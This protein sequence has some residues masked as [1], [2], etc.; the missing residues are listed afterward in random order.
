MNEQQYKSID[1]FDRLMGA[2]SDLPDVAKTKPS[3]VSA[4][5]SLIGECQSVIVQTYRQREVGDF[6]FLQYIDGG[7]SIR[8]ALTPGVADAIA[9]QRDSLGT[10]N[11]KKAAKE[12]AAQD[13]AQGKLPGFMR[14]KKNGG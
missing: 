8:I 10:Q 3:T 13:K 14:N 11:R 9:R 2:L 1:N 5:T 7:K 4:V 12:R 6:I